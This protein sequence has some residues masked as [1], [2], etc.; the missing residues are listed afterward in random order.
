MLPPLSNGLKGRI[1]ASTD[2]RFWRRSGACRVDELRRRANYGNILPGI[3]QL[4][5]LRDQP[6]LEGER[7]LKSL[8][9]IDDQ[10]C[11]TL[12]RAIGFEESNIVADLSFSRA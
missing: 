11:L 7:T 10:K 6:T 3:L 9:A 1:V 2:L 8:A 4:G 5:S 12:E